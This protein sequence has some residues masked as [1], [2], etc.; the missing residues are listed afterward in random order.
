MVPLRQFINSFELK[1]FVVLLCISNKWIIVIKVLHHLSS[2][3]R[4]KNRLLFSYRIE[5]YIQRR[6]DFF[7]V[8][9]SWT[10]WLVNQ[11]NHAILVVVTPNYRINSVCNC[12]VAT[13]VCKEWL[14]LISVKLSLSLV[15]Y[16]DLIARTRNDKIL[17]TYQFIRKIFIVIS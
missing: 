1:I 4:N 7:A 9:G 2:L 8:M 17:S 11:A 14:L 10:T 12:C 13:L 16:I 3:Q 6:L 5:D 15:R